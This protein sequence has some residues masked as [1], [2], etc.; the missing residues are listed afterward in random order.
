MHGR[1]GA[2]DQLVRAT[3]IELLRLERSPV[4]VATYRVATR[5]RHGRRIV[6]ARRARRRAPRRR[7]PR[8][9]AALRR[10]GARRHGRVGP[11]TFRRVAVIRPSLPEQLEPAERAALSERFVASF[12]G[13]RMHIELSRAELQGGGRIEGRAHVDRTPAR[14][15]LHAIVRCV[16]SWRVTPRPGRW[17]L[18]SRANGIPMWRHETLFEEHAELESLESAHWRRFSFDLPAWLPPAVEARSIAWRYEVEVRRSVRLGPDDRA[19]LTPLAYVDVSGLT[20]PRADRPAIRAGS[21]PD[22]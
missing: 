15:R 8:L 20:G 21:G 11:A 6:R 17:I 5:R 4:G 2:P 12:A 9:L 10:A 7:G 13:R 3:S 1:V 22:Q 16:E 19:V 14:G 18:Q